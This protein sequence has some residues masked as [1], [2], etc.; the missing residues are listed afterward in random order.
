V[1]EVLVRF[2]VVAP[3]PE[4]AEAAI[5]DIIREGKLRLLD[6]EDRDPIYE[7]DICDTDISAL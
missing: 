1:Y 6:E 3:N 7:Y 5:N 2:T 4:E